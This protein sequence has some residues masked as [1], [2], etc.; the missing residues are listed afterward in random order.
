VEAAMT[1]ASSTLPTDDVAIGSGVCSDR[2]FVEDD[3]SAQLDRKNII[4][5]AM[6]L[7]ESG[8]EILGIM[9][10]FGVPIRSM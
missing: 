9:T 4:T 6:R 2:S 3:S 8:S 10:V 5:P 7:R 1:R